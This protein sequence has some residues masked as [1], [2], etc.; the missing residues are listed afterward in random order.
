MANHR[1]RAILG[2]PVELVVTFYGFDGAP[3]QSVPSPTISITDSTG[4]IVI[5]ETGAGITNTS[6]GVY[7]Y[8]YNVPSSG[9]RGVWK[10]T[11]TATV[12]GVEIVNEFCFLVV[13]DS[14]AV[15]DGNIKLGDDV[16]FDFSQQELEGLN[17]LIKFLKARL[18]SDGRK[19]KRDK[20]GAFIFD[21]YGEMITEEC[22]VFSDEIL[23]C[24]LCQAL[25]EFN[26]TPFF[27][28]YLFSD[29][30]IYKTFSNVIVEG[31]YVV[32]L[33]SQALIE[34]GRDF[35]IS[36]GGISYQPPQL[37]DFLQSHYQNWLTS[38]RERLKFIKASIRP[39]A[40]TFGTYSNLS[41]GSPA[42]ARL[43]HIRQRKIV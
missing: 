9:D 14:T 24:F 30:I 21:A 31:A 22:N 4:A 5:S 8:T 16:L 37:G 27:T 43:R 11:W 3:T 28:S 42:F 2:E 34:R 1:S 26:S 39:G 33:A 10:D 36:D 13:S 7:K 23:A 38:Y 40:A 15:P 29:Q 17:V 12:D 6:T 18:R 32:A 25:S 20:F 35:T 19:P 41:S